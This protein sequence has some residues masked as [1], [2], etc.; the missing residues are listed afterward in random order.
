MLYQTPIEFRAAASPALVDR[1]CVNFISM[2]AIKQEA[3]ARWPRIREGVYARIETLLREKLAPT[4]FFARVDDDTYLV[5]MPEAD[6]E[7]VNICCLRVS[8]DLF[9]SFLGEYDIGHV[10]VSTASTIDEDKLFLQPLSMVEIVVL[11]EKAGIQDLRLPKDLVWKNGTLLPVNSVRSGNDVRMAPVPTPKK[12]SSLCIEHHF[13]PVW[14]APVDAITMYICEV[15]SIMTATKP[16]KI[17]TMA[18]LSPKDRIEVELSCLHAGTQQLV[19]Q[20][21]LGNRFLLC[22]LFSFDVLGSP[23]GRMEILSYCRNLDS[24]Y[25]QHLAFIISEIPPGVA[26]TRLNNLANILRPFGKSIAASIAPGQ[27]DCFAYQGVGLNAVGI[28]RRELGINQDY[29]KA[30]I[31]NLAL[32][33]KTVKLATFIT[34][35]SKIDTLMAAR[36]ANIQYL[37]GTAVCQPVDEPYGMSRLTWDNIQSSCVTTPLPISA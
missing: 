23:A 31:I 36:E 32:A 6:K 17:L 35:I 5:T 20:I 13:V 3:G 19:Q 33:A 4:D 10:R 16:H 8:Y 9:S 22:T 7:Y 30:D 14:C 26:Q 2:G 24:E 25:R 1:G 18:Q 21:P 27:R 12:L 29:S 28:R 37:S 34:D 15:K 11:A